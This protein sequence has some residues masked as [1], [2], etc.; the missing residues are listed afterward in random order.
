MTAQITV[1]IDLPPEQHYHRATIEALR[2]AIDGRHDAEL[3]VVRTDEVDP[4]DGLGDAVVIGPGSPYR[5]PVAAE[6]AITTARERGL[7][8]VAT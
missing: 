3:R 8:L 6:L 7:P 1:L 2:H 5:N 4:V